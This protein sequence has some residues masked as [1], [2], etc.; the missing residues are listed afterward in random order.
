MSPHVKIQWIGIRKDSGRG[1]VWGWFTET[2][3]KDHPNH[4]YGYPRQDDP[5][6]FCHVFWGSI[7]KKIQIEQKELTH[8]F[9]KE[10]KIR[11]KNFKEQDAEK[12]TS[13]WGKIF[14]EEFSMYL[15]MLRMKG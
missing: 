13:R 12:T 9:L 5:P 7:G 10:A 2:D 1:S 4:N 14:E 6:V 11:T 3:K 8:E 15:L